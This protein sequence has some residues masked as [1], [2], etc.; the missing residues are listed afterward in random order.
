MSGFVLREWKK[1][2][3]QLKRSFNLMCKIIRS[4][5]VRHTF[6]VISEEVKE[7]IFKLTIRKNL[8]RIYSKKFRSNVGMAFKVWRLTGIKSK[9]EEFQRSYDHESGLYKIVEDRFNGMTTRH[10]NYVDFRANDRKLRKIVDFMKK[11]TKRKLEN[12]KR[13]KTFE[14]WLLKGYQVEFYR[15]FEKY[16][17]ALL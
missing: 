16:T 5:S 10:L 12:N 3:D 2:K 8:S 11:Y 9:V 14:G 7:K 17:K 4:A 15:I 1:Q 13:K 6:S